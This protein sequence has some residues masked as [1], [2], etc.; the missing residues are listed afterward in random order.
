LTVQFLVFIM[1]FSPL[2]WHGNNIYKSYHQFTLISGQL[3]K[4][5]MLTTLQIVLF[6]KFYCENIFSNEYIPVFLWVSSITL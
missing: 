5:K 6:Q 2:L 4:G 1:L 3:P